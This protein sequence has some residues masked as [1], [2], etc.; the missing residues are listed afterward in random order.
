MDKHIRKATEQDRYAIALCIADGF[1]KDFSVLS[2][3][4]RKIASAIATGLKIDK[5]YVA[6]T[7][8]KIMATM[9][10][11][12][13]Y[14]RAGGGGKGDHIHLVGDAGDPWDVGPGHRIL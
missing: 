11:S 13:S 3:D 7:D 2:K 10:I 14:G 6:E 5:F 12:D 8:G 1:E 9:A 4:N